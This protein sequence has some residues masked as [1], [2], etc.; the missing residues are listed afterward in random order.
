MPNYCEYQMRIKGSQKAINRVVACLQTDY[1]YSIG[2][3]AHKHFFRVFDCYDEDGFEDNKDGTF[4]KFVWGFCAWSVSSCMLK[5]QYSY[6]DE[7]KEDYGKNFMGTTLDEQSKDCTIEV[8]S[9]EPGMGFSEHYIFQNGICELDD[10]CEIEGAGYDDDGN[11]TTDIDWDT[12]DGD[13]IYKNPHREDEGFSE[14]NGFAWE[15]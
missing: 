5:G 10:T 13:M 11:P 7:C 9:E 4:T 3:P 15:I 12:Y 6:Y 1:D 14:E 2:K 8:F